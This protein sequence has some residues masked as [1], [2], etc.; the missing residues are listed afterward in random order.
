MNIYKQAERCITP[1]LIE[2]YFKA[3]G[4]KWV[5]G[6]YWTL[7]PLRTDKSIKSGT[8][9]ISEMDYGK[10]LQ[11]GRGVILFSLFL[12]NMV[13]QKKKRRKKLLQ[14]QAER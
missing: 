9:S 6:E 5:K 13:Y 2:S 1:H 3:H 8:F 12:K 11:Q 14:M 7:S 10:T 4:S